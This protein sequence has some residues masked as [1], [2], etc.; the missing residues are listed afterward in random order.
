MTG[1]ERSERLRQLKQMVR[2]ELERREDVREFTIREHDVQGILVDATEE[3][4]DRLYHVTLERLP[5][6]TEETHWS[7]LGTEKSE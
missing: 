4:E 6:G 7:Y 5:D 1:S 2:E 3:D